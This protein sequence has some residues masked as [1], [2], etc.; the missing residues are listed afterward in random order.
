MAKR[1]PERFVR[2]L[3]EEIETTEKES[4]RLR[5]RESRMVSTVIRDCG[6]RR[7]S[8]Q[9]LRALGEL[10]AMA[11]IY[12]WPQPIHELGWK[13]WISFSLR[14][15]P[16]FIEAT[17][18]AS[19]SR[20]ADFVETYHPELFAGTSLEDLEFVERELSID[21]CA[22]KTMSA[23]MLFMDADET[24]VIVEFKV[25]AAVPKDVSQL[26]EYL[27]L[28]LERLGH[29]R[30]VLITAEPSS[31][32]EEDPVRRELD[33]HDHHDIDWYWYSVPMPLTRAPARESPRVV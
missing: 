12:A 29:V 5:Y 8:A 27:D 22:G 2:D 15:F 28:V 13:D 1:T 7:R 20:L 25:G 6:W 9:R 21:H 18:F 10:L 14:P 4:G 16:N 33:L 24:P 31:R 32:T 11:G 19:E 30:G 17:K 23:D 3:G 26:S